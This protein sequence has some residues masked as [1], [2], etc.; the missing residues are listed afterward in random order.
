MW[1]TL[2]HFKIV[3]TRWT[4]NAREH[5]ELWTKGIILTF[6]WDSHGWE[7]IQVFCVH[8]VE[9]GHNDKSP[10]SYTPVLVLY[11]TAADLKLASQRN[12]CD[13][14]SSRLIC[15]QLAYQWC[16]K[17]GRG[18]KRRAAVCE[19][20]SLLKF[21]SDIAAPRL[22]LQLFQQATSNHSRT[23]PEGTGKKNGSSEYR[24]W[25]LQTPSMI[26]VKGLW[27]L[28]CQSFQRSLTY[29]YVQ[30]QRSRRSSRWCSTSEPITT[31][32]CWGWSC[33]SCK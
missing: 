17:W 28:I 7:R 19:A 30:P 26:N 21:F 18:E 32:L 20:S 2:S 27:F 25:P 12:W 8:G 6:K 22:L 1:I 23:R 4:E 9:W 31:H 5:I 24:Q 16:S 15:Y 3:L 11:T 29:A 14:E 10:C 13:H 33:Q